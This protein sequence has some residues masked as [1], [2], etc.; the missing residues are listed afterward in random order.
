MLEGQDIPSLTEPRNLACDSY[1][2][3]GSASPSSRSAEGISYRAARL[4]ASRDSR[5]RVSESTFM[6]NSDDGCL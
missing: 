6:G 2:D 1:Q 5:A 3:L 4:S